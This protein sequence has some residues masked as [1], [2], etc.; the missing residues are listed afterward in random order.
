[1]LGSSVGWRGEA[2]QVP[3]S[4]QNRGSPRTPQALGLRKQTGHGAHTVKATCP[5]C[6]ALRHRGLG[7]RPSS[8]PS[9]PQTL[10]SP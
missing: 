2:A 6:A 4:A 5:P 10:P 1:M 3:S 8:C 7:C 9:G